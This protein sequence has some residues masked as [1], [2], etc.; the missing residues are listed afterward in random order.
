MHSIPSKKDILLTSDERH[1]LVN[2]AIVRMS[3]AR[4]NTLCAFS[5]SKALDTRDDFS[6]L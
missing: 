6:V 2:D 3:D 4:Y 5:V 1:E